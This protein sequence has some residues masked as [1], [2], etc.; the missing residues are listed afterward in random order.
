M[1]RRQIFQSGAMPLSTIAAPID[2][3]FGTMSLKYGSL[4]IKSFYITSGLK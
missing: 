1:S 2:Y 3:A 4:G